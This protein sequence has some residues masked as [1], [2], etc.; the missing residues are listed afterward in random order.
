M[1]E[2]L[3]SGSDFGRKIAGTIKE[4]PGDPRSQK[5]PSPVFQESPRKQRRSQERA[6][7]GAVTKVGCESLS[8]IEQTV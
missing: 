5:E 6:W 2:K 8:M 3:R 1:E 4:E 7:M